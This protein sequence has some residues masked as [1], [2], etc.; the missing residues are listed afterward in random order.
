MPGIQHLDYGTVTGWIEFAWVIG[1]MSDPI[2][3]YRFRPES[4]CRKA[5]E[6]DRIPSDPFPTTSDR[7]PTTRIPTQSD[8]IRSDCVGIRR[9]PMKSD[10]NSDGI[11][12][13]PIVGFHHLGLL[14][15]KRKLDISI[16]ARQRLLEAFR[17]DRL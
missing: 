12:L 13:D 10:G 17:T 16:E 8:R 15:F 5:S 6:S 2:V 9:I 14:C 1:W 7:I 11:R 4:D 3:F